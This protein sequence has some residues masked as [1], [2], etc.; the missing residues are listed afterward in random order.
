MMMMM[1]MRPH[2]A[3]QL[4]TSSEE[5]SSGVVHGQSVNQLSGCGAE[6]PFLEHGERQR[7]VVRGDVQLQGRMDA[8][9]QVHRLNGEP[10]QPH[11]VD[12]SHHR[13]MHLQEIN[14]YHHAPVLSFSTDQVGIKAPFGM[15]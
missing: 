14:Q 15:S 12:Q 7:R 4:H 2:A 11:G 8:D 13:L 1:M 5:S 3:A 10:L 6:R 9:Q